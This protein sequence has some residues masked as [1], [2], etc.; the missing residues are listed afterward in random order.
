MA[1]FGKKDE[2]Q[3]QNLNEIV[4]S[5]T[6]GV[7]R[8]NYAVVTTKAVVGEKSLLVERIVRVLFF[9]GKP[10]T[11]TIDYEAIEKVEIKTHFSK[12]DLVSGIILGL[13]AIILALTGGEEG[14]GIFVGLIIIAVMV[15]CAYGKNI[16]IKKK[17]STKV[18][19]L[20]EGIGQKEEIE[21]FC[22][23]LEEK[24]IIVQRG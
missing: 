7:S 17:D 24:G 15:F 21:M 1:I 13:F 12:G 8:I 20:S 5:K 14:P 11:D 3:I 2:S 6:K 16:T 22:K 10:K 9:K 18:N 4:F 23:K 19:L